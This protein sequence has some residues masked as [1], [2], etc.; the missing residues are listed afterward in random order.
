MNGD[1]TTEA[2]R[3]L[4][5]IE[6]GCDRSGRRTGGQADD[7]LLRPCSRDAAGVCGRCW[8][9]DAMPVLLSQHETGGERSGRM[10]EP[11][12]QTIEVH[13]CENCGA[14]LLAM[15]PDCIEREVP[16]QIKACVKAER[17]RIAD[18]VAKQ[19]RCIDAYKQIGRIDPEC[20]ACD[21]AAEIREE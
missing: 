6:A 18:W 2:Q 1:D 4:D 10:S 14:E 21:L 12:R 19:C 16:E 3:V 20:Q 13:P 11:E 5:R 7:V 15:C 17:N 9:Q 8:Q